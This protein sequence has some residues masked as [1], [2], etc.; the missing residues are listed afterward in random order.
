MHGGEH[1]SW[2]GALSTVFGLFVFAILVLHVMHELNFLAEK[3]PG[4]R[5]LAHILGFCDRNRR[6]LL[7]FIIAGYR[8]RFVSLYVLLA[9]IV[10]TVAPVSSLM[11]VQDTI[12]ARSCENLHHA[13][14]LA[15]G[16][17][18]DQCRSSAVKDST[19]L[20]NA[21]FGDT[22]NHLLQVAL[23]PALITVYGFT[24]SLFFAI[25][26]RN[27]EQPLEEVIELFPH[28]HHVFN[29]ALGMLFFVV[30]QIQ[31]VIGA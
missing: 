13:Q 18:V 16:T 19:A 27:P 14:W 10:S 4:Q 8:L 22:R 12:V 7:D 30:G 29:V 3:Y 23:W 21:N 5:W 20:V 26:R 28:V 15:G 25:A 11:E 31:N 1:L 17:T 9:M 24:I 2:D 6:K